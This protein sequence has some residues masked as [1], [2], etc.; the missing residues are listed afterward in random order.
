MGQ[1]HSDTAEPGAARLTTDDGDA[2]TTPA[3]RDGAPGPV[4][5]LVTLAFLLNWRG[6]QA[7]PSLCLTVDNPT[8]DRVRPQVIRVD[9]DC[10]VTGWGYQV[11]TI[12]EVARAAERIASLLGLARGEPV[13]RPDSA[14]RGD[15]PPRDH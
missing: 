11:A 15:A 6:L 13:P 1:K 3:S 4:D 12:R 14:A 10:Y 7:R 9:G 2:A 8:S 5:P